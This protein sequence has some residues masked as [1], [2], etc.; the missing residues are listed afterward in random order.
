MTL[1][2]SQLERQQFLSTEKFTQDPLEEH[3]A[4]QRE[5]VVVKINHF[6]RQ[7]QEVIVKDK[8]PLHQFG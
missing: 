3:F 6:A 4:R 8:P 7:R 5:E 1:G 2:T